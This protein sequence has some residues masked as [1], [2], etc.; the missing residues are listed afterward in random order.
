LIDRRQFLTRSGLGALG[1][2]VFAVG[3]TSL[4][5]ACS[6]SSSGTAAGGAPASGSS[7]AAATTTAAAASSSAAPKKLTSLTVQCSW[8]ADAEF[9]GYF[10]ADHMGTFANNGLKVSLT[11]GGPNVTPEQVVASGRALIGLDGADAITAAKNNGAP[12]VILG[13]QYQK[14][15]L[16]VLSLKKSNITK[17]SDLVGKTLGVPA[18][19]TDQMTAFLKINNI[20]PKSVKF[21]SYGTDP[22]PIANG[23]VDAAVAF[24]TTDPYLL[25]EKGYETSTF[26]LADFGYNIYNDCPFVLEDTLKN[27]R[28]ELVSFLKS[29][30]IGWEYNNANPDYVVPLIT[31]NYGKALGLSAKSQQSQNVAQIPLLQSAA[32]KA[33]GLFWMDEAGIDINMK[34]LSSANIK[35]DKSIFD[36]SVLQEV[37]HGANHI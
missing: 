31:D 10:I 5:A 6:S 25:Q 36:M 13:A 23:T 24:T 12:L 29:A 17:P 28:D 3:G 9:A 21:A 8:V 19:S 30:I 18:G 15:P 20:N 1:A 11:P 7:S 22:T 32:T 37:Y 4:L 33:H 2:G 14:N 26:V 34:T 16:G 27:H 35:P